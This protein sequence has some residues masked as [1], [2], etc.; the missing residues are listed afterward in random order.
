MS[1]VAAQAPE[2]LD[3]NVVLDALMGRARAAMTATRH[4]ATEAR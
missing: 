1:Q 3:V 2:M 4:F